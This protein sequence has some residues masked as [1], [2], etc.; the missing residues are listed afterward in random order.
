MQ[1]LTRREIVRRLRLLGFSGPLTGGT[2]DYMSRGRQKLHIPNEHG[3]TVSV[4]LIQRMLRYG[5]I[6][7]EEWESVG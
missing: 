2:H 6:S 4:N 7:I 5:G 1:P 3:G